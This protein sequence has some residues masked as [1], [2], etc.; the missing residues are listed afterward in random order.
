MRLV[1]S[2]LIV[3]DFCFVEFDTISKGVNL[4]LNVI[5]WI[6]GMGFLISFFDGSQ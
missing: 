4:L 6:F 5:D 2:D 3:F 1:L